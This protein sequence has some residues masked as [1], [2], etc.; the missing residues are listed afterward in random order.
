MGGRQGRNETHSTLCKGKLRGPGGIIKGRSE[1]QGRQQADMTHS[2]AQRM[3]VLTMAEMTRETLTGSPRPPY[4][5]PRRS[6]MY[7][8][9]SSTPWSN[10]KE[11][12]QR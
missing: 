2:R 1:G 11:G 7:R 9:A 6:R 3:R 4:G 12:G 5:M 10:W 8:Q